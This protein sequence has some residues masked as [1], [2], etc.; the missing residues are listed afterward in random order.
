M[1]INDI[2]KNSYDLS[3]K[4]E[5]AN[6]NS[7]FNLSSVQY[8]FCFS[9]PTHPP[10]PRQQMR[11]FNFYFNSNFNY[12]FLLN[13]CLALISPFCWYYLFWRSLK[14][15]YCLEMVPKT[16][17]GYLTDFVQHLASRIISH[18]G[19]LVSHDCFQW[20]NWKL[21]WSKRSNIMHKKIQNTIKFIRISKMHFKNANI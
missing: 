3:Y 13:L 2:C 7:K 14:S 18:Y 11:S 12:K 10:P 17:M 21:F 1:I 19:Y 15:P 5:N 16:K 9:P 6:F 4:L 8:Q 20:W